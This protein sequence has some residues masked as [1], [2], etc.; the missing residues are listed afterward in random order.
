[1]NR[2]WKKEIFRGLIFFILLNCNKTKEN[3][4]LDLTETNS[5][6]LLQTKKLNESKDLHNMKLK[7]DENG[8]AYEQN[9]ILKFPYKIHE[10]TNILELN[11]QNFEIVQITENQIILRNLE[12]KIELYLTKQ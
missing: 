10:Q 6:W 7:F 5:V 1:M 3:I 8:F 11:H 9:T 4:K 12:S 2:N